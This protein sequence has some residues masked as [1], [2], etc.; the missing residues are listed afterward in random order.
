MTWYAY[1]IYDDMEVHYLSF[2]TT[3]HYL[4]IFSNIVEI[5]RLSF[6][7][8]VF[9]LCSTINGLRL[10]SKPM[11]VHNPLHSLPVEVI[12]EAS[13]LRWMM[14]SSS[15]LL[16]GLFFQ[17]WLIIDIHTTYQQLKHT[18]DSMISI[19]KLNILSIVTYLA[20][21]VRPV[22]D[23]RDAAPVDRRFSCHYSPYFRC[24][25]ISHY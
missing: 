6:N 13:A 8:I 9:H 19:D 4:L 1:D 16:K 15:S 18:T 21:I 11:V 22:H 10:S 7:R 12:W 24:L 14:I 3:L 23:L 5:T 2:I 17:R 25:G 20:G